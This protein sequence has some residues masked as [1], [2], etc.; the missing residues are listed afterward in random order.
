MRGR[1]KQQRITTT[2]YS[3][4]LLE[5]VGM[6]YSLPVMFNS[7]PAL[8]RK[9]GSQYQG[10]LTLHTPLEHEVDWDSPTEVR[11]KRK[12]QHITTTDY[13]KNQEDVGMQYSLAVMFHAFPVVR[14]QNTA[15]NTKDH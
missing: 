5:D 13:H 4:M 8:E 6:Q 11:G 7:F 9:H 3:T 2:D 15:V 1:R 12:Q 14:R 10:S